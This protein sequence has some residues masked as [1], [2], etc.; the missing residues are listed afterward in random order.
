VSTSAISSRFPATAWPWFRRRANRVAL[1]EASN[2]AAS[3][4]PVTVSLPSL[5]PN[6]VAAID[7]GGAGNTSHDDLYVITRENP[8]PRETLLRNIGA[9]QSLL[10]DQALAAFRSN[11]NRFQLKS[12]QPLRVGVFNRFP[13]RHQ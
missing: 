2:A 4:L 1:L 3:I 9:S 13:A 11:P 5:G 12:G 10:G 7:I 8:G 6:A